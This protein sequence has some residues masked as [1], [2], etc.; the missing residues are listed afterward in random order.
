MRQLRRPNVRISIDV[1]ESCRRARGTVLAIFAVATMAV[2]VVGVAAVSLPVPPASAASLAPTGRFVPLAPVRLVD[3]RVGIGIA[4]GLRTA[5]SFFDVQVTG[6]VSVAVGALAVVANV[7][8][9]DTDAAGYLTV[10]PS[11][12][13]APP[14]SNVNSEGA[15][16]TAANLSV[17]PLGSDGRLRIAASM[18]THVIVDVAGYF[19]PAGASAAGRYAGVTPARL[20]DSRRDGG[21]VVDGITVPVLGRAGLPDR[22][23]AAVA[24]NLT[25]T[26]APSAGW[27]AALP[28]GSAVVGQSSSLNVVRPGQTVA[29]LVI[30]PVGPDGAIRIVGN[31]SAA[32]VV[33][34]AGWFSDTSLPSSDAGLYVPVLPA[35]LVD[36]RT[37]SAPLAGAVA[38][39]AAGAAAGIDGLDV[40][41]LVVTITATD[42]ASA[43]YVTAVPPDAPRPDSSNLNADHAGS[44]VANT[45]FATTA[46]TA[47][48]DLVASM[49]T[50]LIVDVE[51]YFT[52][53]SVGSSTT[54]P[55]GSRH[56]DLVAIERLDV[57]ANSAFTASRI[58]YLSTGV[59]GTLVEET[60]MI[61]VPTRARPSGGWP[62]ALVGHGPMGFGDGC[63]PST[64]WGAT[65]P[66]DAVEFLDQGFAVVYP[67]YEGLGSDGELPYLV[68]DSEAHSMLD[69]VRTA[70][71]VFGLGL[72]NSVIPW[73]F[74]GGGHAAL[75]AAELAPQYTPE[76]HV[77]GAV[78]VDPVSVVSTWMHS[79]YMSGGLAAWIAYGHHVAHPGLDLG[80]I[81]SARARTQ[82]P[83]LGSQCFDSVNLFGTDTF[84]RD[85]STAP[86]WQEVFAA[87]DPGHRVSAPVFLITGT[88]AGGDVLD[89]AMHDEYTANACA[90]GTSV[91]R[92]SYTSTH[93]EFWNVAR[94]T[95]LAWMK[96]RI[97]GT[98]IS[99]CTARAG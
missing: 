92:R 31:L 9:T 52:R 35:R 3:T 41:A 36:T 46:N 45:A 25:A 75:W 14:T 60:G 59:A 70:R 62:I 5:G 24:L 86:G 74:S 65:A 17:L 95:A 7:T 49:T 63:A 38:P 30:V 18:G 87:S 96:D 34:V 88:A 79:N 28:S 69:A 68:G 42:T 33:D 98:P 26:D 37:G 19:E 16:A 54:P 81:F 40:A 73:G 50:H 13:A 51:G 8:I 44:T 57:S 94:I 84:T 67:D 22:G 78:G 11:D 91:T 29:N 27:I 72:A 64:G 21:S 12:R 56:G 61:Y 48:F 23:V 20:F 53:G 55:S 6:Q 4:A 58:R 76:L 82:L 66:P 89:P 10:Y 47:R 93:L 2:S 77:A 71:A 97:A 32:V 1:R 99:G 15:G 43:G 39:V 83:L 85:P 90:L 80:T